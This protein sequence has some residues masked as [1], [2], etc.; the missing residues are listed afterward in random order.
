MGTK[1]LVIKDFQHSRRQNNNY[2]RRKRSIYKNREKADYNSVFFW[3]FRAVSQRKASTKNWILFLE[4]SECNTILSWRFN[5]F[6]LVENCE[7]IILFCSNHVSTLYCIW[8]LLIYNH[9]FGFNLFHRSHYDFFNSLYWW[10]FIIKSIIEGHFHSLSDDLVFIW[11][12]VYISLLWMG[13]TG[14]EIFEV[15]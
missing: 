7:Y 9:Y 4:K 13:T 14:I 1:N 3:I 12:S 5:Y 15:F 8:W 2:K 6:D 10:E 11:F